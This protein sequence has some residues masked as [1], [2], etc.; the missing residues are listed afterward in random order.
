VNR[1]RSSTEGKTNHHGMVSRKQSAAERSEKEELLQVTKQNPIKSSLKLEQSLDELYELSPTSTKSSVAEPE[2]AKDVGDDVLANYARMEDTSLLVSV[3]PRSSS[4]THVDGC[5]NVPA[6][7][8][9]KSLAPPVKNSDAGSISDLLLGVSKSNLA[10]QK[11]RDD[12]LRGWGR[13]EGS[14]CN[15][16]KSPQKDATTHNDLADSGLMRAWGEDEKTQQHTRDGEASPSHGT[17]QVATTQPIAPDFS[18]HQPSHLHVGETDRE[19][20]G[21]ILPQKEVESGDSDEETEPTMDI[22]YETE[23]GAS[24]A[25]ANDDLKTKV[26]VSC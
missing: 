2:Q 20:T 6:K 4:A 3:T 21:L 12:L 1:Q 5:L 18:R 19:D 7:G 26:S 8:D 25:S 24:F 10:E 9:E 16:D 14:A 23:A 13:G 11:V 22:S 15:T 17:E